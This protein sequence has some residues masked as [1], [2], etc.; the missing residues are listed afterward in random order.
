MYGLEIIFRGNN[1]QVWKQL[2]LDFQEIPNCFI[3]CDLQVYL[4]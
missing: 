1:M 4:I 3:S 2:N